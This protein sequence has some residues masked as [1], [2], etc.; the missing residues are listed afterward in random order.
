MNV[1][2]RELDGGL[3]N[4]VPVP[5]PFISLREKREIHFRTKLKYVKWGQKKRKKSFF[6]NCL[7]IMGGISYQA[8]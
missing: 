4:S 6:S 1:I 5:M 2:P 8:M 3:A 7:K